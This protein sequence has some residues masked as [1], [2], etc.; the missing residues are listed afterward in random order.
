MRFLHTF[1]LYDFL[2]TLVSLFTAF[3]LGTLIGA[4]RQYRQRSAGLRTNV[5]VAVGAA[6]FVDIGNRLTGAEG[7]VRII[8]YVVSGIGFLGAGTIMKE[9]MNVRGLNTAATLWASA[10]VGA[11]AGA[12]LIAQSVALT[13]FVLAGNTLLRPLVNA[14]DRIPLN[15]QTSEAH[16][17]IV[18][19]T[20]ALHA[21]ELREAIDDRLEAAKYPVRETDVVYRSEDIV[22]IVSA[23]VPLVVESAELDRIVSDLTKLSGVRHA[24]WNVSALE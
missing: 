24:T 22:E 18:V 20:D 2:D 21:A 19:T 7:A 11:C 12:D 10:A 1:Q 15:A 9:G 23:L 16:Y 6:A 3:V 13:L 4:E 5:L 8:A 14:I 17:K